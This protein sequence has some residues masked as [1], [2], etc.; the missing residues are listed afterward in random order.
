[1]DRFTEN[2]RKAMDLASEGAKRSGHGSVRPEH[3]LW[4]LIE[5]GR[6]FTAGRVL[7]ALGADP[8][9][10]RGE[11]EKLLQSGE[12]AAIPEN[13]ERFSSETKRVIDLSRKEA[14]R[15]RH[16]FIG[17]EHLLLGLLR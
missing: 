9:V 12:T 2:A 6:A 16:T 17:T 4:A 3:L 8:K 5:G 13:H 14:D 7:G 11:V 15:L 10:L 1:F